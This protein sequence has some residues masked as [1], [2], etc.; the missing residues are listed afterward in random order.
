MVLQDRAQATRDAIIAGAAS[1]FEDFG[2]GNA[3]L[4][5]V[6]D[7]SQVTKGALYFH[8]R[9]KE[10]LAL[11]V[12]EEQHNLTVGGSERI[13]AEDAP[14]LATMIRMCGDFGQQ[15][16][17]RQ[18]VRAGIRL[19]LEGPAFG[20]PVRKPYED[21]V[22]TMELLV[23]RAQDEGD[24]D[25]SIDPG[26]LA[27][28]IVASFTGVQMVSQ[29]LTGRTDVIHRIHQMWVLILPGIM[30]EHRRT[31]SSDFADLIPVTASVQ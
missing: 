31:S 29:V 9:S 5:Q 10:D 16:V 4:A 15:L 1:V 14:A 28:Y 8:F 11:A 3:S 24:I 2:Y 12:I 26:E 7:R 21:W 23:R 22:S 17:E 18:V 20:H 19:T 27:R 6:A 30:S 13:L 25:S